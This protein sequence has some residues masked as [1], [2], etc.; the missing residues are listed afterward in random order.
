MKAKLGVILILSGQFYIT[1]VQAGEPLQELSKDESKAVQ[2]PL[3]ER[4]PGRPSE[5]KRSS[6]PKQK[7]SAPPPTLDY[8]RMPTGQA[9]LEPAPPPVRR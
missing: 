5:T 1:P 3:E 8:L 9:P 2:M 6:K 4:P 7:R